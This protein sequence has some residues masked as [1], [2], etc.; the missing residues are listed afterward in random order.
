M[1]INKRKVIRAIGYILI[2]ASL[3]FFG[4]EY[5]LTQQSKA[6][7]SELN[8]LN[9]Q[10]IE[11]MIPIE[12]QLSDKEKLAIS[13][14][15]INEEFFGIN[16]DY[17][18]WIEIKGTNINY[19]IV[20]GNDNDYYLR[21]NFRRRKIKHGAIFMDY[22]NKP[23]YS[24]HHTVIYG[25]SMRDGTMFR[26]LDKYKNQSFISGHETI[27]IR[28]LTGYRTYQIFSAYLVDATKTGLEIP[29]NNRDVQSLISYY[30]SQSRY[31]INTDTSEADHVL[32]LV[33]CNYDVDNGRI[34]VHAVLV[35]VHEISDQE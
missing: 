8:D 23:D 24:D 28:T 31:R 16:E 20:L 11:N 25:H 7:N 26:V 34:I 17:V 19:P 4:W 13:I 15:R 5:Y 14:K 12:D 21:H 32:T 22:R 10:I 30:K 9:T 3:G 6:A 18:G 29:A 35:D 2:V 1:K 33:S 27:S